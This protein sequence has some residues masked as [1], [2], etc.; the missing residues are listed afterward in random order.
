MCDCVCVCVRVYVSV[1]IHAYSPLLRALSYLKHGASPT[2]DQHPSA[3]FA[4][5]VSP[6]CT[7][8][9]GTE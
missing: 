2:A 1:E 3:M 6:G 7:H 4:S 5:Y 8:T 9:R